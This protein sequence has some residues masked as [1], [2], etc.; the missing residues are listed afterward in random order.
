MEKE[1]KKMGISITEELMDRFFRGD[2]TDE[3]N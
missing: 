2:V 3:E 1:I